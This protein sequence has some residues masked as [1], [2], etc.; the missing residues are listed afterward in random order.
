MWDTDHVIKLV[1][2]IELEIVILKATNTRTFKHSCTFPKKNEILKLFT[3]GLRLLD[4]TVYQIQYHN[5]RGWCR[6]IILDLSCITTKSTDFI[7]LSHL[8]PPFPL[9]LSPSPHPFIQ[10]VCVEYDRSCYH[11]WG[12]YTGHCLVLHSILRLKCGFKIQRTAL[13]NQLCRWAV[14]GSCPSAL[15]FTAG[16][17]AKY[18]RNILCTWPFVKMW[19]AM[20]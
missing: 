15:N 10:T 5:F 8:S 13:S 16:C 7:E 20:C 4:P 1:E 12:F 19:A 18:P 3:S 6:S 17:Y 9:S 11:Q 2:L 14:L